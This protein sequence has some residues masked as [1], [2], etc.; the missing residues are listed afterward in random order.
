MVT[1]A[2]TVLGDVDV[3]TLGRVDSHEHLMITGGPL[4]DRD[5]A[6]LL[7]DVDEGIAEARAFGAAGGGTIVD[8]LP[9]GCGRDPGSLR[10]ISRAAGVHVIATTGFYRSLAYPP[11]HWVRTARRDDLVAALLG[12]VT[13]GIDG[14]DLRGPEPVPTGILP[15]VLK[16]ATGVD[17]ADD[18][19]RRLVDAVALAHRRSGLPILTHAEQGAYGSGQ[20]DLLERAGVAPSRVMIGHL[21]RAPDFE[22][23]RALARRGAFLGYDGLAREQRRPYASVSA[24]VRRLVDEGFAGLILLGG[25]VGRRRMRTGMGGP[26]IAGVL[27]AMAPELVASGVAREAVDD[28]LVANAARF[29]QVTD[30]AA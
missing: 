3:S 30:H 29:L 19:E 24:V 9:A 12:E 4:V 23:H 21:D 22:A 13:D 20:L 6:V 25:D 14:D 27:T 11:G 26:G 8:A 5:P 7:A 2:R 17:G 18:L 28:M 10:E 16:L 1:V 15:G